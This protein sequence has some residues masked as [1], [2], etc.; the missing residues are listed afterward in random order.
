[1]SLPSLQKTMTDRAI[2][3]YQFTVDMNAADPV[4]TRVHGRQ[5]FPDFNV[6]LAPGEQTT[7]AIDFLA[8]RYSYVQT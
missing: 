8:P 3:A 4:I 5:K 2:S 1:M 7:L 6:T